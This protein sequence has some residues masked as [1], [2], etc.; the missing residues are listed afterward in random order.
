MDLYSNNQV[1]IIAEIGINHE[2]S[3]DKCA[4]MIHEAALA[5]A[6]AV[7][8]QTIDAELNYVIGSDSYNIFKGSELSREETA[9]MFKL[10]RANGLDVFTTAGD[11]DTVKWVDKL[12]PNYWKISSGLLTHIPIINFIASL[13][14]PL[15]FSTGMANYED[16]DLAI[17]TA[18]LVGNK[19]IS[20]LQCTSLYPT[21]Y[22]NL[23]LSMIMD[24][25]KRY[26]CD[27]GFSDHSLG[28]EASVLS[29]GAGAKIIEKHFSF[30]ESREGY[31]H[32]ISLNFKD[33]KKMVVSIRLA[34]KMMGSHNG[35]FYN[36]LSHAREKYLRSVVAVKEIS[37]GELFSVQN[38]G[39]KRTLPGKSGSEPKYYND[40]LGQ[41]AFKDFNI[42]DP[43]VNKESD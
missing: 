30:D 34:E 43:I 7:K 10:A 35:K 12:S 6:N 24:L 3:V 8:L 4:S 32:K 5:G 41:I 19:N 28:I 17:K 25:S 40:L 2:G 31:D 27:V 15:I 33:F 16:I 9:S 20:L 14:R 36:G 23:N 37:K 42:N 39:V 1:Y 38:I 13:G 29:V 21:P 26:R 11:I 18:H 22:E